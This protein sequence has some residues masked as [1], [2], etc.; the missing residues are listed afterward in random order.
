MNRKLLLAG[1]WVGGGEVE[2]R[3]PFD[4]RVVSNVAQATRAQADQALHTAF[5][6]RRRLQDQPAGKRRDVLTKIAAGLR[7]RSEEIAKII[8]DEGGKPIAAARVEVARAVETFTLAASELATFG[9]RTLAV[10]M[11]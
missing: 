3:S 11:L 9:G 2:V 4:G 1:Q 6:A 8:C 5:D 10:D 7:A